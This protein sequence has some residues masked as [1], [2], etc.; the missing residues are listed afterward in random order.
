M[1]DRKNGFL[2][3][4]GTLA[5]LAIGGTSLFG[6]TVKVDEPVVTQPAIKQSAGNLDP[7]GEQSD[8]P[9]L[10]PLPSQPRA[11][12]PVLLS[13]PTKDFLPTLESLRSDWDV[14]GAYKW[15]TAISLAELSVL[16]YTDQHNREMTLRLIGFDEVINLEDG[17]MSGFIAMTDDVVVVAFRGT[18]MLSPSDWIANINFYWQQDMGQGRKLHSGFYKG[19]VR[20]ADTIKRA[21]RDRNPEY[22]WLTGHSLGGAMAT[23]CAHDWVSKGMGLSGLITFGQPRVANPAMAKFLNYQ[24]STRYLRFRNGNDIVPTIPMAGHRWISDY[25]HAGREAWFKDGQ[26]KTET[27]TYGQV[28]LLP[29]GSTP[30]IDPFGLTGLPPSESEDAA[31]HEISP[32]ELQALQEYLRVNQSAEDAAKIPDFLKGPNAPFLYGANRTSAIDETGYSVEPR[33]LTGA[34]MVKLQMRISKF[35]DH[36]M[37]EYLKLLNLSRMEK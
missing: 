19:Y 32:E 26:I 21:L 8:E 31:D 16:A 30:T 37:L 25:Q 27:P 17:P 35:D 18:D 1:V 13:K 34:Q 36:S 5:V 11:G 20:F 7:F 23:C 29:P 3:I 10:S 12:N 33:V 2:K 14:Q 22:V 24:L 6:Q 4:V 28:E 15:E 9:I